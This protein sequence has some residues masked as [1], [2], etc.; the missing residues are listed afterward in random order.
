MRKLVGPFLIGLGTFLVVAAV[1][2]QV[3]APGQVERTP[4]DTD[5]TTYLS[6][7]AEVAGDPTPVLAFS[8]NRIDSDVSDDDVA[9]WAASLCVVRDEDDIDGCVD[10][11]D[12]EGRL[13]SAEVEAFATDR[14]TALTVVNDGY[15][16][17]DTPQTEGLQNKWPFGAEKKTYPVWDGLVGEA[18]DATYEGVEEID[19]LETY[20]YV[21]A[22]D[23][24]DVEVLDGIQGSYAATTDYYVEPRTGAIIRQVVHQ[25]RVGDGVGKLLEMDLAFTDDQ[26]A[27][28]VDEANSNVASLRLIE[29]VVPIVGYAAGTLALLAGIAIL[30]L[31]RRRATA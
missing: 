24:D 11:E 15:L 25:E 29:T 23:A 3:W 22:V 31:G 5:N 16:P 9:V 10:A 26:V 6:G 17:P 18:I 8:T 27:D 21:A 12:P 14:R 2:A 13:I 20:H 28:N 1:L 4:L 30:V 19:G 7:E